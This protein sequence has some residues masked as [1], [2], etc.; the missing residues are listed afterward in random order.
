MTMEN[1]FPPPPSRLGQRTAESTAEFGG[2]AGDGLGFAYVDLG[3]T[4]LSD[5][6]TSIGNAVG[7]CACGPRAREEDSAVVP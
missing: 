7:A 2:Q 5:T 6:A 1:H 3:Y 4:Y